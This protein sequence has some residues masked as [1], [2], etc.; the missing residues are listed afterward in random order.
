MISVGKS[1]MYMYMYTTLKKNH[2]FVPIS[3][4]LIRKCLDVT[5][6]SNPLKLSPQN[7]L[8]PTIHESFLFLPGK[9]LELCVPF[10]CLLS[11]WYCYISL[12]NT[13]VGTTL[14]HFYK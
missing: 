6:V 2:C 13:S 8:F 14:L 12:V 3:K 9:I 7:L 11:L 4:D 5:R 10:S 1:C